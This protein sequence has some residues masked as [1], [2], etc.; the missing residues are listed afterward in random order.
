M[1][2]PQSEMWGCSIWTQ[3]LWTFHSKR[4]ESRSILIVEHLN[5]RRFMRF[6]WCVLIFIPGVLAKPKHGA[7]P[8]ERRKENDS[9]G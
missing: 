4:L 2:G 9:P 7:L 6:D 5:A 3:A 8:R 1:S